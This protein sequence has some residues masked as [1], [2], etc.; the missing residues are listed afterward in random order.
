M[1]ELIAC[2]PAYYL[3]SSEMCDLQQAM[4]AELAALR[5]LSLI[6]I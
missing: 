4:Q 1:R 3:A 2:F 6:H 5:E